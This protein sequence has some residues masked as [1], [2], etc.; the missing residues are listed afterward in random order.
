[1]HPAPSIILFTVLTGLGFGLMI[2]LGLAPL[3][4]ERG[5]AALSAVLALGLAC[6]G[7]LASTFHLRNP[8]RALLAFSQWRSSWLSREAV[9]AAL[10]IAF[11]A[12]YAGLWVLAGARVVALGWL[13]AGLAFATVFATSMI[14]AQLRAVPR[15]HR[16]LVP[17]LFLGHALCGGALLSG[18]V[19]AALILLALW[20]LLQLAAFHRG[21]R[22]LARSGSSI[23]TAT[24][25]DALGRVRLLEPPH[26]G[27]NYLLREMV[28]VIGRKHASKLRVIGVALAVVVPMGLLSLG[29]GYWVA[30]PAVASHVA[31]ALVLRWLFFAEAEHVVGFYYDRR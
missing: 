26:T 25:L 13:A 18:R 5:T 21:D 22:A 9:L 15:W 30:V 12:T 14:Y 11:F 8:Q 23:G 24:G 29:L 28:F 19:G 20:G 3:P 7:L 27:P 31:G 4:E 16:G 10:A 17:P 6:A 2:W 1:M